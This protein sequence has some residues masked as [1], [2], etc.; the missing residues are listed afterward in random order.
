MR[1]GALLQFNGAHK[2]PCEV[3][4]MSS[5]ALRGRLIL[6]IEESEGLAG[7][8]VAD[9]RRAQAH[10]LG[11]ARTVAEANGLV[12][13]LRTT[14]DA[15]V[16]SGELFGAAGFEAG[17]ALRRDG[18][19]LIVVAKQAAAAPVP[20]AAHRVLAAPVAARSIADTVCAAMR[21]TG[22]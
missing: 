9:L 16:V 18:V 21:D 17:N 22:R 19:P 15:A 8:L 3:N 10:I 1:V 7:E 20:Q 2:N 6:L 5:D 14:P 12:A 11:P 13:R 4:G